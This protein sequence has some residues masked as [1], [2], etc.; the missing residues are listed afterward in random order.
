[1]WYGKQS[2]VISLMGE[3]RQS[4]SIPHTHSLICVLNMWSLDR[5]LTVK[6]SLHVEIYL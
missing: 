6:S 1:M 2:F 3:S 5:N 4:M